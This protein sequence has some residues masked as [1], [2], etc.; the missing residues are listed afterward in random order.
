[1]RKTVV[2][3]RPVWREPLRRSGVVELPGSANKESIHAICE[4]NEES[5]AAS[6]EKVFEKPTESDHASSNPIP[7]PD[8]LLKLKAREL[9]NRSPPGP[10]ILRE[11]GNFKIACKEN[12]MALPPASS[13]EKAVILL[14]TV[15]FI[16]NLSCPYAFRQ[17]WGLVQQ[18][19]SCN[20]VKLCLLLLF[21]IT[22]AKRWL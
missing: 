22:K 16:L 14:L 5:A 17:F 7:C 3:G 11:N 6:D 18:H 21:F 9:G 20:I 4:C 19:V 15:Y 2:C 13:P 8:T 1:M 12:I 10:C